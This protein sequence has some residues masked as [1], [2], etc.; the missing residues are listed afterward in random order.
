MS[1]A[2]LFDFWNLLKNVRLYLPFATTAEALSNHF[3]E[4]LEPLLNFAKNVCFYQKKIVKT[5]INMF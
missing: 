4:D 5:V 1:E 2:L 3:L